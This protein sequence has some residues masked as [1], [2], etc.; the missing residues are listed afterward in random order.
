MRRKGFLLAVCAVL[1]ACVLFSPFSPTSDTS[2][3]RDSQRTLTNN[4]LLVAPLNIEWEQFVRDEHTQPELNSATF[5]RR[6]GAYYLV[7]KRL[8]LL[9]LVKKYEDQATTSYTLRIR[10]EVDARFYELTYT[11]SKWISFKYTSAC[12]TAWRSWC[13]T[14]ST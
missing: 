8:L 7:N 9:F 14:T 6:S 4:P 10:V 1:L 5:L 13:S 11:T 2:T 3:R 12:R